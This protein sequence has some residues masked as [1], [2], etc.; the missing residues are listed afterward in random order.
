MFE[1]AKTTKRQIRSAGS[2][3]G[4]PRDEKWNGFIKL[5]DK[6]ISDIYVEYPL[7]YEDMLEFKFLKD[8]WVNDAQFRILLPRTGRRTYR[9]LV[10][11]NPYLRELMNDKENEY[12]SF[13]WMWPPEPTL[14]G[15]RQRAFK[16]RIGG[17]AHGGRQPL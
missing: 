13:T 4:D 2:V 7:D 16:I 14:R 10:M 1:D 11:Y 3:Y 8:E 5:T 12:F 17:A 9:G 6:L 15:T